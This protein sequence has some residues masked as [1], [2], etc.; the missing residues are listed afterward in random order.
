MQTVYRT[1][2][3][4]GTAK[5]G[6]DLLHS[7]RHFKDAG[8]LDGLLISFPYQTKDNLQQKRYAAQKMGTTY[9]YDYPEMFKQV[10]NALE[11]LLHF[12]I[13]SC[14]RLPNCGRSMQRT[15]RVRHVQTRAYRSW[16]SRRPYANRCALLHVTI[17]ERAKYRCQS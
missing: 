6:V 5:T 4:H 16:V 14:R 10:R 1:W 15:L 11:S 17:S 12:T 13:L 3:P 9:V 2:N 8:P 7:Q